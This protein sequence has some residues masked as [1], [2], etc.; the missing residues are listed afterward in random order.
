M[1]HATYSYPN[2]LMEKFQILGT[3]MAHGKITLVTIVLGHQPSL[4]L[5]L[6]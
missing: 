4:I 3:P 2:N 5:C 6:F 1:C